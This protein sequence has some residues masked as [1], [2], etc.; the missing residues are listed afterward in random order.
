MSKR[1]RSLLEKKK[2]RRQSTS[3]KRKLEQVKSRGEGATMRPIDNNEESKSSEER[4]HS[5]VQHR[6]SWSEKSK[7]DGLVSPFSPSAQ[8]DGRKGIIRHLDRQRSMSH[9]ALTSNEAHVDSHI[10][11]ILGGFVHKLEESLTE[12]INKLEDRLMVRVNSRIQGNDLN[13][14]PQTSDGLGFDD[15][16][17]AQSV[18]FNIEKSEQMKE[19]PPAL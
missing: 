19:L 13:F 15:D 12:R 8:P 6:R 2:I 9:P 3:R 4:S 7:S 11:N 10:G 18:S 17:L 5:F 14:E 1:L 16:S